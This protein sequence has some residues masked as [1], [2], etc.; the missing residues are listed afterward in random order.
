MSTDS[1]LK[2]LKPG[3]AG[4]DRQLLDWA[5]EFVEPGSVVWDVGANVGVFTFAAA[6][7][8]AKVV[9]VEPDP[10]LGSLLMRS[11]ALNATLD[12]T[13][14]AAALSGDV[15]IARLQIASGGRASN[16]LKEFS[17]A[18]SQFNSA[19]AEVVVPTILLDS[20]I[21]ISG[22]PRFVKID[23]EGAEAMVLAGAKR[24]LSEVRPIIIIESSEQTRDE[25]SAQLRRHNYRLFDVEASGRPEVEVAT[26]NT[27]A[28]P[29]G[30]TT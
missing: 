23:V 15:G 25:V 22:P 1:Q 10:Y 11:Q 30:A 18:R 3:V 26:F 16:A 24:L 8:G 27:L 9:S 13:L 6:G 7:R 21:A 17:G 19:L 4:F 2:Y 12:I 5:R 28:L 20:L 14:V 29:Q